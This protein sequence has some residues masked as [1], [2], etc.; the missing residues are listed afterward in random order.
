MFLLGKGKKYHFARLSSYFCSCVKTNSPQVGWA[1][2]VKTL[3]RKWIISRTGAC[4]SFNIYGNQ[5][6]FYKTESTSRLLRVSRCHLELLW[7]PLVPPGISLNRKFKLG[8]GKWILNTWYFGAAWRDSRKRR[9]ICLHAEDHFVLP[10]EFFSLQLLISEEQ[11]YMYKYYM[12][13][14]IIASPFYVCTSTIVF[15]VWIHIAH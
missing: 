14:M 10:V 5:N 2:R 11:I 4:L 8:S 15:T 9:H 7:L 6:Q 3:L 1:E 12:Y 13:V